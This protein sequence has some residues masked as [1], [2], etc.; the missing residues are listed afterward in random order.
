MKKIFYC[1]I[2]FS[3]LI[4]FSCSVNE[5][6][7]KIEIKNFT[8]R[9]LKNVKIGN[10]LIAWYVGPGNSVDYWI[11][12]ELKGM[13]TF[14]GDFSYYKGRYV[15][16]DEPNEE[17]SQKDATFTCKPGYWHYITA[18]KKYFGEKYVVV[19]SASEHNEDYDDPF[20]DDEIVDF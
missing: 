9:P 1:L 12:S 20:Y 17:K 11:Y 7:G 4:F 16:P 3:I 15:D 10:T 14:E 2:I 8:D 5:S 19:F 18:H 6:T 13:L